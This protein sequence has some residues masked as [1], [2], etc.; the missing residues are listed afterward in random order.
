MTKYFASLVL[1]LLFNINL[2]Y[3]QKQIGGILF[4]KKELLEIFNSNPDYSGLIFRLKTPESMEVDILAVKW[5]LAVIDSSEVNFLDFN[6]KKVISLETGEISDELGKFEYEFKEHLIKSKFELAFATKDQIEQ[7]CSISKSKILLSGMFFNGGNLIRS[8]EAFYTFK[9]QPYD[10]DDE[11]ILTNISLPSFQ[12][13]IPCPPYWYDNASG[14]DIDPERLII[15][16]LER[17]LNELQGSYN[18]DESKIEIKWKITKMPPDSSGIFPRDAIFSI[19]RKSDITE[20]TPI[21]HHYFDQCGGG[22]YCYFFDKSIEQDQYYQYKITIKSSYFENELSSK[23][24]T[25]YSGH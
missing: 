6:Y 7:I 5:N 8:N 19:F 14:S 11:L 13:L 23:T 22:P 24:I 21:A 15:A 10:I 9:L 4:Q 17:A 3:S 16:N 2:I 20:F 25:V 1:L 18:N 12:I